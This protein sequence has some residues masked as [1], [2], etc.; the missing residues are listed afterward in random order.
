MHISPNATLSGNVVVGT[1]THI[2]SGA[3]SIQGI[4]I[5]KWCTIG[6]G[7]VVIRDVPDFSTVVGNPGRIIKRKEQL[8][9]V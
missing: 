5:G 2:G 9:E 4:R 8:D 1:G 7:T 3:V 6:A